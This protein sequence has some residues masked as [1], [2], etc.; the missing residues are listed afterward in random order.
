MHNICKIFVAEKYM[1]EI[2]DAL[3]KELVDKS[4]NDEGDLLEK[5]PRYPYIKII[6]T[7]RISTEQRIALVTSND[8]DCYYDVCHELHKL[9]ISV[10]DLSIIINYNSNN[11]NTKSIDW[12]K[13]IYLGYYG[14]HIVKNREADEQSVYLSIYIPEIKHEIENQII[15]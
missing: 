10:V 13:N 14:V 5:Q 1:K 4:F 12:I 11:F 15:L 8:S 2:A 3:N 9:G 6:N 7:N